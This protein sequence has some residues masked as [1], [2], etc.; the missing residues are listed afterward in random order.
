[1]KKNHLKHFDLDLYQETLPN[2]LLI[3]VIPK[4]GNN[5]YVTFITRYGSFHNTFI[6]YQQKKY[7]EAPMGVAHFLEHKVFEQKEGEDPFVFYTRNGADAN[8]ST[9]YL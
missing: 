7:Y 9:S 5:I 6:P 2:G 8:A 4:E 1:M 3:N